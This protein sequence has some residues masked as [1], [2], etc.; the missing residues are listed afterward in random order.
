MEERPSTWSTIYG[1]TRNRPF[2]QDFGLRDQ[3]QRSAVSAMSNVAEGFES[4][5]DR[6]FLSYLFRAKGSVGEARCHLYVAYDLHY[7]TQG[8]FDKA[9]KECLEVSRTIA[10]FA[11]YLKSGAAGLRKDVRI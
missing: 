6:H 9:L 3:I 4:Q 10:G 7:I 5:S 8:E 2:C 1:L 11:K